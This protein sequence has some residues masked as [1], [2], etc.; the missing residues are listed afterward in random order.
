MT[1]ATETT[2]IISK[3]LPGKWLSL[4]FCGLLILKTASSRIL[5]LSLRLRCYLAIFQ[6]CVNT[7]TFIKKPNQ[8]ESACFQLI[9]KNTR[10]ICPSEWLGATCMYFC[11]ELCWLLFTY[12]LRKAK[13]I[14]GYQDWL[15]PQSQGAIAW[16]RRGSWTRV[17]VVMLAGLG[18]RPFLYAVLAYVQGKMWHT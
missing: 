4:I 13:T 9:F 16:E 17:L 7:S 5:S 8:P 1:R 15:S 10:G 14:T 18:N 3:H 12:A 6:P 11:V 2:E